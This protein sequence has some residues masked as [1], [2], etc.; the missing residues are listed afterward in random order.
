[1]GLARAEQFSIADSGA[2]LA[3]VYTTVLGKP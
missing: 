3:Q 2:A 1:L